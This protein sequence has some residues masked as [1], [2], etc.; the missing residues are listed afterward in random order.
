MTT[1]YIVFV[2]GDSGYGGRDYDDDYRGSSS[3]P[4]NNRSRQQLDDIRDWHDGKR[5]VVDEVIG[6]VK[7]IANKVKP[8]ADNMPDLE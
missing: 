5:G 6:K 3:S 7:E 1:F 4:S 8:G 2:T